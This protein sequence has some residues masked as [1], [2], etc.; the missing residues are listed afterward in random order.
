MP[1]LISVLVPIYNMEKFLPKC[2]DSLI[3][4]THSHLEIILVDDGSTDSSYHICQ[5]YAK[6]DKRITVISQPNRGVSA[7]R[8]TALAHAT[9]DYISFIDPD[10][11]INPNMYEVMLAQLLANDAD[12]V[13]CNVI[14]EY[15]TRSELPYSFSA[16][17]VSQQEILTS[18][19]TSQIAP[20]LWR[21]LLPRSAWN[22]I[23][24]PTEYHRSEDRY[25]LPFVL[26]NCR[27]IYLSSDPCYH[28]RI[29]S[30]SL[31]HQTHT[32]SDYLQQFHLYRTHLTLSH[33]VPRAIP[34]LLSKAISNALAAIRYHNRS[35]FLSTDDFS[36]IDSFLSEAYRH[37]I[38]PLSTKQKFYLFTYLYAQP[39]F[40][41]YSK[42]FFWNRARLDKKHLKKWQS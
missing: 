27:S 2:L 28:Y 7:A 3:E 15:S 38:A 13:A 16:R 10:D 4:Q 29:R 42:V 19:F 11:W 12:G 1:V 6:Q 26:K 25:T 34:H 36:S 21:F 31:S 23:F 40:S 9:G 32:P 30:T 39:L 37:P 20:Y 17:L 5:S 18:I 35:P 24:F 14:Y 22:N 33:S 8:N 41:L